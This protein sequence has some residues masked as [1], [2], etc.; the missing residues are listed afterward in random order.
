[1]QDNQS[2]SPLASV[3]PFAFHLVQPFSTFT[4]G[5]APPVPYCVDG[6]LS[7]GGFSILGAKPKVGKSSLSRY[8]AVAVAKG[9][10]FLGRST[11]KGEVLLLSLEDPRFHS[12]NH[13]Q[14]LGYDP[15]QDSAIHISGHLGPTVEETLQA[16]RNTLTALPNI[17]LVVID[18]LAK[19][20]R[21]RDL[22]EYMPVLRGCEAL[23]NVA[24]DFPH[25]HILAVAHC[26]KMK[27][28]DPFDSI[29]GSTALRGETD[30]NFAI[31]E[32]YSRRV[33]AVETRIGRPFPPSLLTAE[34]AENAGAFLVRDFALNQSL[35][36]WK[37][38][39]QQSSKTRQTVSYAER[40]LACLENCEGKSSLQSDVLREVRGMTAR[41]IEA[42]QSLES[43]GVLVSSGTPKRLTLN[44]DENALRLYRLGHK[45]G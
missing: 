36:E 5:K 22:S 39:Q 23:R 13:L 11:T 32:E 21:L 45:E 9:N 4:D 24:R 14:V 2:Q 19:L 16:L 30:T 7:E 44:A 37:A 1:M 29:L 40:V 26:K 10:P 38:A 34:L 6:L 41:V 43:D 27:T 8:L 42:I 3:S 15:E 17:R 20:L 25:V 33:V 28:D 31:F 12:D 18:H 35:E